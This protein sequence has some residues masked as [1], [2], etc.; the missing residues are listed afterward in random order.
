VLYS[1]GENSTKFRLDRVGGEMANMIDCSECGR[2][3]I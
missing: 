1:F 3:G 2:T